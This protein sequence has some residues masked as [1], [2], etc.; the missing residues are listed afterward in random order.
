MAAPI[1]KDV[2][3]LTRADPAHPGAVAEKR[4]DQ[5]R[6]DARLQHSTF[7]PLLQFVFPLG[8][9]APKQC[10]EVVAFVAEP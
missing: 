1:Q 4:G 9:K 7:V 6:C 2:P 10:P 5:H 8:T 3:V